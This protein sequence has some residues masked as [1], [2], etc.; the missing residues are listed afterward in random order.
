MGKSKFISFVLYRSALAIT[1]KK[2]RREG[3]SGSIGK[4]LAG[5]VKEEGVVG[6][7]GKQK[8]KG[9]RETWRINDKLEKLPPPSFGGI[10]REKNGRKLLKEWKK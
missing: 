8:K 4:K 10:G 6:S 7:V 5:S 9:E 1:K 2:E 3:K